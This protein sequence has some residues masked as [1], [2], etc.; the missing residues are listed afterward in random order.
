M[1]LQVK[2]KY[3]KENY[4]IG[5]LYIDDVWFSN[6][7]EDKVRNIPEEEKIHGQTAIPAG[8]YKVILSYSPKFKRV[9]PEI[10]NVPYFE[11]IRIHAGNTAA[12][13]AGCLL[14]GRN[15][16]RGKLTQSKLYYDKLFSILSDE[17][18]TEEIFI[19]F[20]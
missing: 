11:G 6:T 9:M 4:T 10:L 14:I 20:A 8:R 5:D 13:S 3:F 1:L 2:R 12:D 18:L 7:L 19:N 16:E 17:K 15:T